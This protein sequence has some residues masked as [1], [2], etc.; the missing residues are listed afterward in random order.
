METV[1]Q[2]CGYQRKSTDQAPDWECPACGKAYSKTAHGSPASLLG[3]ARSTPSE[4]DKPLVDEGACANYLAAHYGLPQTYRASFMQRMVMPVL[5]LIGV[6]TMVALLAAIF[7][8]P[9]KHAS[10]P[11]WVIFTTFGLMSSTVY[12]LASLTWRGMTIRANSIVI[13]Q[14][15]STQVIHAR[16]VLGYVTDYV[17]VN[18]YYGWR[19]AFVCRLHGSLEKRVYFVFGSE[20]LRDSRLLGLFR[21]MRNYGN[22]SLDQLLNEEEG[23]ERRKQDQFTAV[24]LC[25]VDI[26]IAW[27]FWPLIFTMVR[28]M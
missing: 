5:S 6:L 8:V 21:V 12:Y 26:F 1:C 7:L 25:L 13:V 20:N 14:A 23:G 17:R 10:L 28:K 19:Y 2:A 27:F 3:N 11:G 4:P 15:F 24:M 9:T 18:R 16:D 22:S